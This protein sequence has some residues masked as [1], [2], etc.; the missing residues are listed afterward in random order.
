MQRDLW[1]LRELET[2]IFLVLSAGNGTLVWLELR[3]TQIMGIY[4][5]IGCAA[6]RARGG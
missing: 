6:G 5:A 1:R 4:R 2:H 3:A